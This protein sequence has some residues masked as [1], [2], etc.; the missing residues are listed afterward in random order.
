MNYEKLLSLFTLKND[1]YRPQFANPNKANRTVHAT[2]AE[3]LIF[4]D[5]KLAPNIETNPKYPDIRMVVPNSNC[6]TLMNIESLAILLSKPIKELKGKYLNLGERF[7][8]AK[9]LHKLVKVHKSLKEKVYM[10]YDS[11]H[12]NRPFVFKI[13]EVTIVL[14]Q[15]VGE[16]NS[17]RHIGEYERLS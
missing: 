10:I 15:V 5:E 2:D 4:F 13:G 6:E 7:I 17:D 11:D 14:V 12:I 1:W 3:A 16:M 9:N 8:E